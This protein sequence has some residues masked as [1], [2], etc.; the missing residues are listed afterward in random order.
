MASMTLVLFTMRKRMMN[1]TNTIAIPICTRRRRSSSFGRSH[2]ST[3]KLVV[4][5]VSAESALENDAATIPMV[6]STTTVWPN[7][8]V[9]ANMGRSSSP[10]CGSATPC[11]WARMVSRTPSERNMKLAGTK[12]KP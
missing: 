1:N 7:S 3:Q 12:A 6:N 2:K 9:A 8:P 4:S 5:A 11:R 10:C